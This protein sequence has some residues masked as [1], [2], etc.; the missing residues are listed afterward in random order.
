MRPHPLTAAILVISI[1]FLVIL[2]C[3]VWH[4]NGPLSA[5]G[6]FGLLAVVIAAAWE[7]AR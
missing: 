4:A 5:C 7:S 1:S 2:F 6:I 3:M